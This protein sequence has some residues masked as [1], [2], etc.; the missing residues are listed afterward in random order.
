MERKE[1]TIVGKTDIPLTVQKSQD[2]SSHNKMTVLNFATTFN[3]SNQAI[4]FFSEMEIEEVQL[5]YS[6]CDRL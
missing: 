6:R 4:G 3:G 2:N 5:T 1:N